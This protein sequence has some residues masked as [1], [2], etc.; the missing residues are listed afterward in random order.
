ME[1]VSLYLDY[2]PLSFLQALLGTVKNE[3]SIPWYYLE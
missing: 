3:I 2:L 1:K